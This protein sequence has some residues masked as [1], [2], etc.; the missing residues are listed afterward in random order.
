MDIQSIIGKALFQQD[1]ECIHCIPLQR[2][3]SPLQYEHP[4]YNTKLP[5]MTR[6]QFWW[7]SNYVFIA[8]TLRSFLSQSGSSYDSSK[9]VK[10]IS[11]R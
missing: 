4:E 6:L 11:I 1:N 7:I 10:L 9:C 5:L 2:N 3:K 8:V